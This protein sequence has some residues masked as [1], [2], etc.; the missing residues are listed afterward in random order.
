MLIVTGSAPLPDNYVSINDLR[1][2]RGSQLS[3]YSDQEISTR[4]PKK[5]IFGMSIPFSSRTLPRESKTPVPPMPLK[6][7]R[8]MGA[9]PPPGKT[10]KFS[11]LA[12]MAGGVTVPRSDT[13]KSLPSKVFNQPGH[14]GH[15]RRRSP[16]QLSPK[17]RTS[18]KSSPP[19]SPKK[20]PL[21]AHEQTLE[22]LIGPRK[23]AQELPPIP[24]RKDS[25]PP[26]LR[27]Q[28]PDLDR[29]IEARKAAKATRTVSQLLQPP[30][31]ETGPDDFKDSGMKLMVPSVPPVDPIPSEGGESPSKYCA[32]GE[33]PEFVEGEPL[34]SAHG[35]IEYTIE[36][37]DESTHSAPLTSSDNGK[38]PLTT[39][40]DEHWSA[41]ATPITATSAWLQRGARQVETA[42]PKSRSPELEYL[43]PTVYSPPKPAARKQKEVE[44]VSDTSRACLHG[45]KRQLR[46]LH[47]PFRV[48]SPAFTWAAST[49]SLFSFLLLYFYLYLPT[50]QLPRN[51]SSPPIQR[52]R[53]LPQLLLGRS[54][55]SF[56]AT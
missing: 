11:P 4:S 23:T 3:K 35:V 15:S 40:R 53:I 31:P 42:A 44:Q 38:G 25:L 29:M 37:E 1:Q 2:D 52:D 18:R 26:D 43:Y 13:S 19:K 49:T 28:F 20:A 22:A 46:R 48:T 12:K 27:Q 39:L 36:E 33:K 9:T 7:A 14:H 51:L 50:N 8:L 55:S 56:E 54:R 32:P 45:Q 16:V 10:R 17:G 6:A 24:P 47:L 21:F 5:K 34:F 30:T 41:P